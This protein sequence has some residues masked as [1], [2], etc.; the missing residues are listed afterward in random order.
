MRHLHTQYAIVDSTGRPVMTVANNT[1]LCGVRIT[2][3]MLN[4]HYRK[5]IIESM[6]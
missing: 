5:Y 6:S 4:S 2:G 3:V 1:T